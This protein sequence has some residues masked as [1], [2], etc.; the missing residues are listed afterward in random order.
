MGVRR[1]E[2][3]VDR[4]EQQAK[5]ERRTRQTVLVEVE[6]L[7]SNRARRRGRRSE[8]GKEVGRSK[9]VVRQGLSNSRSVQW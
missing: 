2:V 7:E 9:S 8:K 4:R 5:T 1:E 3:R 6:G